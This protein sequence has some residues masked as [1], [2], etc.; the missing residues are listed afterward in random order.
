M[1]EKYIT[2]LKLTSSVGSKNANMRGVNS[3][4]SADHNILVVVEKRGS[5]LDHELEGVLRSLALYY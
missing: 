5:D 3:I 2:L 1:V 4:G